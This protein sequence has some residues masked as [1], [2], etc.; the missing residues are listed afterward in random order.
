MSGLRRDAV[1]ALASGIMLLTGCQDSGGAGSAAGD[2]PTSANSSAPAAVRTSA[3]AA[4]PSAGPADASTPS[5]EPAEGSPAKSASAAPAGHAA[6]PAAGCR[7]L[8]AD[9]P[10]KAEVTR[11]YRRVVRLEHIGPVP[12]LF[13]Y[14]RCGTVRYA[15]TRFQPVA[16]AGQAELVG[17]Q[18]EGS[19]TK[20][21]RDTGGG[22]AYVA[23]DGFPASA[24]GCGDIAAIPPALATVWGDCSIAP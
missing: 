8:T 1:L 9:G 17:M 11:V 22:W 10:V 5:R 23:T 3:P 13:F 19:A 16:G 15:A 21:F 4:S 14:G 20:Y 18:D 12:H 24:H 2:D 7:N 6:T